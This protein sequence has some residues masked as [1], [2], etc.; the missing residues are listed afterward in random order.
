MSPDLRRMLLATSMPLVYAT[1]AYS[2]I[3]SADRRFDDSRR[4]DRTELEQRLR[5]RHAV[6]AQATDVLSYEASAAHTASA[7]VGSVAFSVVGMMT[8][9]GV[10]L[11]SV[12][13][14][15]R[16]RDVGAAS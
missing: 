14:A 9:M 15:P 6:F 5:R 3:F 11:A 1:I 4:R 7:Y 8:F 12:L 10:T 13:G 16:K 2:A